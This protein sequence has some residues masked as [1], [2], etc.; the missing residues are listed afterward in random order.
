MSV[1]VILELQSNPEDIDVLKSAIERI[2]PAKRDCDGCNEVHVIENQDNPL[3]IIL[4]ETWET[5]EQYEK[6]LKWRMEIGALDTI[7]AMLSKLP[8]IRYYENL[9]I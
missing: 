6:Y 9:G 7:G 8:S 5:R 2:L 1:Y 4:I 3:N